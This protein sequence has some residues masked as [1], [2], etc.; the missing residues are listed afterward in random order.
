MEGWVLFLIAGSS[1]A[2]DVEKLAAHAAGKPRHTALGMN[3]S[4][5][6][7]DRFSAGA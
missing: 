1:K 6:Y 7:N 2:Q 4:R 5:N 3:R